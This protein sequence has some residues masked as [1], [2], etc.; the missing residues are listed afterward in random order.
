MTLFEPSPPT[1]TGGCRKHLI[2][3][4]HRKPNNNKSSSHLATWSRMRSPVAVQTTARI[5][6]GLT[7]RGLGGAS[8]LVSRVKFTLLADVGGLGPRNAAQ[9]MLHFH[10]RLPFR[11]RHARRPTQDEQD[12]AAAFRAVGVTAGPATPPIEGRRNTQRQPP[13]SDGHDTAQR[14]RSWTWQHLSN[15]D[16]RKPCPC[17]GSALADMIKIRAA[18]KVSR[19]SSDWTAQADHVRHIPSSSLKP[20][21]TRYV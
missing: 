11:F 19:H 12:G 14:C 6:K 8:H 15:S 3:L 21:G 4:D 20:V 13:S 9:T 2:P 10:T 1:S 5:S 17:S 16:E 7:S 18:S